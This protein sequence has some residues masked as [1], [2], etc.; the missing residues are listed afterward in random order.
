[1]IA[2]TGAILGLFLGGIICWA[3]DQFGLVG[4]GMENAIVSAYPVKL[5]YMDFVSVST[6]IVAIT[7]LISFYP[8]HLASRSY[9]AEQL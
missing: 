4:M 5:R 2:F 9:S 7:F 8:A 1:M 3:Q 6:V